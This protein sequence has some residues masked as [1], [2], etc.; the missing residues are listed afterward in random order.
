MLAAASNAS[1]FPWR[2]RAAT[3][4][5][6][7]L[8]AL[9]W[10][11]APIEIKPLP[12]TKHATVT[13][14]GAADLSASDVQTWLD[15]EMG[16]VMQKGAVTGAVVV[17]VK[18]G[19]IVLSKGYG[20]ADAEA[21]KPVDPATTLFRVASIS[22]L[23]TWTAVMQLVEKHKL[24]LDADIN[25]YLDFIVPPRDGK[26]V[27]LRDLMTHTAGFEDVEKN[28][29][30]LSPAGLMPYDAWVK[31]WV[32][33]RIYPAGTVPAYSSYGAALAGYIVQRVSG[34]PFNDYMARHILEPLEMK[35]ASFRQPLPSTLQADVMPFYGKPG[36]PPHAFE[37]RTAV[38]AG[39]LSSSG[40]DM[41]RFMVAHLQ[42]GRSGNAQLL[43]QATVKQMQDYQR[44][45]IPGL[46]GM[47]LG[48]VRMDWN[49]QPILGHGGDIDGFHS[50]LA[51]F[52]D[53]HT[54]IFIATGGGNASPL[55]R[56]IVTGFADR[57]FPPLP[58]LK[59]ATLA[60]DKAHSAQLVGRYMP[61]VT[62]RS[63]VLA[64]RDALATSSIS[65]AADGSLVTPMFGAAHW[66]EIK[67][68]VWL[69]DATGRQL[70]AV[71][72]DG[73]VSMLSTDAL[74]PVRVYLPATGWTPAQIGTFVLALLVVFALI[75]LSWP[76]VA[77]LQRRPASPALVD[78]E[79]RWYRLS[80]LTAV[81][82][83]MFAGGWCLMLPRLGMPELDTRL[84]L[85]HLIGILAVL[86]SVA[87]A[88][89]T[90]RAWRSGSWWRRLSGSILLLACLLAIAFIACWHLLS[91]GLHY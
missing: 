7:L 8:P 25:R 80:R 10:A 34:Q 68:Y 66:R 1:R 91:P 16:G 5:L 26:P 75:A 57:Y 47:A 60:T 73:K 4:A 9:L 21:K 69:D 27:T 65:M 29:Y 51:L 82:F 77:L 39:A 53:H 48:F 30:A 20:Y 88:V 52:P 13:Q 31:S 19:E 36:T 11:Q 2:I 63:N 87:V 44:A 18:D 3:V 28:R 62:S 85:L 22:K 84:R 41:A 56:T 58:Q 70:G 74:A 46:P 71:V 86:G 72:H 12:E 90:W 78:A 81:L 38:P 76:I 79:A 42:Y 33:E 24:D 17:V 45:I 43:E 54:G 49:G 55:L 61:S 64:L 89:E 40:E 35:H 23:F 32:P 15:G 59:P 83:L 37:L 14:L 50:L 6:M 67:P